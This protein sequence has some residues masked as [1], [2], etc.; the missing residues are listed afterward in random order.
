[1][2]FKE[3]PFVLKLA[4]VATFYNSFV[5]FEELIIDR[6]DYWQYIPFYKKGMFCIWDFLALLLLTILLLI[7]K[8]TYA[9]I[10]LIKDCRVCLK[11]SA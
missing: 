11:A 7:D 8:K 10:C 5:L 1:M 2:K 6:L 4:V 9:K 3:F